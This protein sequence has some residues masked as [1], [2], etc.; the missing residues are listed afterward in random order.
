MYFC[1]SFGQILFNFARTFAVHHV[2][3]FVPA[4]FKV[5]FNHLFDNL[6]SGKSLEVWI[7]KSVRTLLACFTASSGH[8]GMLCLADFFK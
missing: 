1:F 4:L 5:S 7:P 6:E 2:K 8:K 3:S